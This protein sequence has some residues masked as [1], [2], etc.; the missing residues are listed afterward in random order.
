MSETRSLSGRCLC[1]AVRFTAIAHTE[2]AHACHCGMCRKWAAGPF[3]GITCDGE[4]S[5]EADDNLGVYVSSDWA[6]R[7]F[8]KI[9]GSSLFWKLR[10][11]DHYALSAGALDDPGGLTLAREFYIDKKP[12]YYA[13]AGDRLRLTEADVIKMFA[14]P[15]E[16]S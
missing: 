14:P 3:F 9:C 15:Q 1:G 5:F 4:I 16:Q 2:E 11:A 10:G 7:G 13:L 6:E 12:S 8:C